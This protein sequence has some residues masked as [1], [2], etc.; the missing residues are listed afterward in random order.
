MEKQRNL[1]FKTRIYPFRTARLGRGT[2]PHT[3]Y[4]VTAAPNCAPRDRRRG[5]KSIKSH[6]E[7]GRMPLKLPHNTNRGERPSERSPCSFFNTDGCP[8]RSHRRSVSNRRRFPIRMIGTF[9]RNH[10]RRSFPKSRTPNSL[11]AISPPSPSEHRCPASA[12]RRI[13]HLR[14]RAQSA[15]SSDAMLSGGVGSTKFT[16]SRN[17]L[18]HFSSASAPL[19]SP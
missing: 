14:V 11:P 7:H 3:S 15:V 13:P 10:T 4:V 12:G 8:R 1:F 2:P 6:R 19:P 17:T 5:R 9:F 18:R 16:M